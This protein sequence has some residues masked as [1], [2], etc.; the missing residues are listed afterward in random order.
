MTPPTDVLAHA[1]LRALRHVDYVAGGDPTRDNAA[2]VVQGGLQALVDAGYDAGFICEDT[3]FDAD[4][5]P[6]PTPPVPETD[7]IFG[8]KPV[9][10]LD[11]GIRP[12]P[13]FVALKVNQSFIDLVRVM[14]A[15]QLHVQSYDSSASLTRYLLPL[16]YLTYPTV[17]GSDPVGWLLNCDRGGRFWLSSEIANDG[18]GHPASFEVVSDGQITI[19]VLA[20]QLREHEQQFPDIPLVIVDEDNTYA[21]ARIDACYPEAWVAFRPVPANPADA[22]AVD[23]PLTVYLEAY[24]AAGGEEGPTLA[25]VQVDNALIKQLQRM[26]QLCQIHELQEVRIAAGPDWGP[27]GIEDELRLQNHELVVTRLGS[28]WYEATLAHG[29]YHVE[30]RLLPINEL[31]MAV[32]AARARG[33]EYLQAGAWDDEDAVDLINEFRADTEGASPRP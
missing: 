32:E 7:V 4:A 6:N 29:D 12:G 24:A 31:A 20:Q 19:D 1:L 10:A 14:Q 16:E 8:V 3:Q 30:T 13:G 23:K 18:A 9:E 5:L 17:S 22:A 27:A 21:N 11:E 28:F 33:D 25:C 26:S 2:E 15:N